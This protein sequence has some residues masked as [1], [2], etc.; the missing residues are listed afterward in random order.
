M[1]KIDPGGISG[2]LSL[3]V[4]LSGRPADLRRVVIPQLRLLLCCCPLLHSF[5]SSLA[6]QIPKV[7]QNK[8]GEI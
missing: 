7:I 4:S 6:K 1:I 5:Q 2:P 8:E 3:S